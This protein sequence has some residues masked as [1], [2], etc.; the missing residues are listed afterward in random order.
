MVKVLLY[1][2]T[3]LLVGLVVLG[4]YQA[5]ETYQTKVDQQ[6]QLTALQK[7]VITDS[8]HSLIDAAIICG[9]VHCTVTNYSLKPIGLPKPVTKVKAPPTTRP[10]PHPR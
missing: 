9:A 8:N 4:L 10:K 7:L 3:L 6:R 2:V 1:V 5:S